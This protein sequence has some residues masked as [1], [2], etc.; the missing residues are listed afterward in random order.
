MVVITMGNEKMV[1]DSEIIKVF[2][3][4]LLRIKNY[5]PTS[6]RPHV[7]I[8]NVKTK[9]GI[10]RDFEKEQLILTLFHDLYR[11]GFISW[12]LNVGNDY[13]PE[14]FHFTNHGREALKE[15]DRDPSNPDGYL[16]F[17]Y[18]QAKIEPIAKSYIEE[19][20]KTYNNNCYKSTAVMIGAA[21]E[22]MIFD[23]RDRIVKIYNER[24]KEIPTKIKD[25][26]IK[27]V[28]DQITEELKKEKMPS[29]LQSRFNSNWHPFMEHIRKYRNDAGHP[30]SI[31]PISKD[32]VRASFII[33]P[34]QVKLSWDLMTW[35]EAC[36]QNKKG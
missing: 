14:Y 20:L 2:N 27:T 18:S 31:D 12:G 17:L 28:F 33:F 15:F 29:E 19:G 5:D 9:L 6:L 16:A 32:S 3:E 26:R 34:E 1:T 4:E 22:S 25:W 11:K 23:M 30:N 24:G 10:D 35:F 21:T 36:L 8:G 7:F 13:L